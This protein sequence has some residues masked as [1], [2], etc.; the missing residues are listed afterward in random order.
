MLTEEP[1]GHFR[2]ISSPRG[3]SGKR[4]VCS[5]LPEQRVP[6]CRRSLPWQDRHA[7]RKIEF[8]F[9]LPLTHA[10]SAANEIGEWHMKPPINEELS[11]LLWDDD[12]ILLTEIA[13]DLI[14]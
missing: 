8:R 5:V 11:I 4:F 14:G 7:A 2:S 6:V 3:Q 1:T 12:V 13:H 9:T 10:I